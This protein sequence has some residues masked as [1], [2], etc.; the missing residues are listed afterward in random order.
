MVARSSRLGRN[1]GLVLAGFLLGLALI[2]VGVYVYYR[3]VAGVQSAIVVGPEGETEPGAA[4]E[5]HTDALHRVR[6]QFHWQAHRSQDDDSSPHTAWLRMASRY[7][8]NGLG[9]QYVEQFVR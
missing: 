1:A 2:L 8:G 9:A 5:I 3:S 7:A 4:G 6:V